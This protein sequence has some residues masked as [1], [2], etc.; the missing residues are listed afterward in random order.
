ML[1]L[2]TVI[3]RWRENKRILHRGSPK[4]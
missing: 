1:S 3:E 2:T 4:V